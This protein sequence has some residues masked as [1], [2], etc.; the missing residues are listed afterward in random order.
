MKK[1]EGFTL[2]ELIIVIAI[3]AIIAAVAIPNIMGA[4][5]NSRKATDVSNGKV[6]MNA[7]ATVIAKK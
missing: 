6:L 7:A 4:V 2:I 5:E 3:L 1:Q